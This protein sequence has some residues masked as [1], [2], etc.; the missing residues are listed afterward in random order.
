MFLYYVLLHRLSC[1]MPTAFQFPYG[2][3]FV[4]F[5]KNGVEVHDPT[6]GDFA[7]KEKVWALSDSCGSNADTWPCLSFITASANG[8]SV[9]PV[10]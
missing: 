7:I 6:I 3:A 4:L 2:D 5:G 1:G 8:E 9:V 10:G